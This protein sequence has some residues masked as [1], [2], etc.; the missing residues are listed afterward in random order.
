MTADEM[1]SV[2]V[3][4]LKKIKKTL[5]DIEYLEELT[6]PIV[7]ENSL[8]RVTRMDAINTKSVNEATLRQARTKLNKLEYTLQRIENKDPKL[9]CC[10]NCDEIIPLPRILL[11]PGSDKCIK[12]AK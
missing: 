2:K 10:S 12:C 7:P 5:S 3:K 6:K 9:G 1:E 11:M 4:V 8:G